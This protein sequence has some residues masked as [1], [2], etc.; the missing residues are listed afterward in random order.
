MK[1]YLH[2][3]THAIY[4]ADDVAGVVRVELDGK[5]GVF[6]AQGR[7]LSGDKIDADPHMCGW[8]GG[9]G[10]DALI[11]KPYKSA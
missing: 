1:R 11:T 5:V 4:T 7:W 6:N 3:L 8:V 9:P 2:A 10:R